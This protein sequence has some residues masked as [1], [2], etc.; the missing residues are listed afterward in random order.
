MRILYQ[1]FNNLVLISAGLSWISAQTIKMLLTFISTKKV[2]MERMFGAGGMPSAHSAM[3]CSLSLGIAHECRIDSPE[4]ALTVCFA[5][6][7]MYDAMGVRR[8][9]G[10]QAK[11]INRMADAMEKSECEEIIDKDLKEYL[12]HTPL[13][14]LVGALLGIV[15]WMILV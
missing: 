3:V 4:F 1:L 10:E 15:I 7:V 5:G 2:K 12:G 14:V 9:A 13:E 8:A 6:V 11:A